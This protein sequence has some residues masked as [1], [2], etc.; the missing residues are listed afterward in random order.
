M[1]FL[2][3]LNRDCFAR[4]LFSFLHIIFLFLLIVLHIQL[5]FFFSCNREFSSFNFI[6]K[7]KHLSV[8]SKFNSG[9]EFTFGEIKLFKVLNFWEKFFFFLINSIGISISKFDFDTK[10][11]YIFWFNNLMELYCGTKL[12]LFD[13]FFGSLNLT[14]LSF[15]FLHL[16]HYFLG[17]H[18]FP[19]C[20][21]VFV[22]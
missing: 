16:S 18:Y 22:S 21:F 1:S 15:H 20:Y 3:S 17:R 12:L 2:Y 5:L 10:L 14:Y 13:A 6:S 19:H 7:S 4:K 9:V 8:M 11:L